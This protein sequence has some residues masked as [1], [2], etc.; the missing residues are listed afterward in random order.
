[1]IIWFVFPFQ[2]QRRQLALSF[3]G[4]R[5]GPNAGIGINAAMTFIRHSLVDGQSNQFFCSTFPWRSLRW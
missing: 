1:M 4:E 3:H 5:Q 2:A